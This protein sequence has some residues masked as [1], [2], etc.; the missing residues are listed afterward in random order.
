MEIQFLAFIPHDQ[1]NLFKDKIV[2]R[3]ISPRNN[4]LKTNEST[5]TLDTNKSPSKDSIKESNIDERAIMADANICK[6]MYSMISNIESF[7][8]DQE[9]KQFFWMTLFKFMVRYVRETEKKLE[10]IS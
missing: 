1:K 9:V 3:P 5:K 4:I 10:S 2:F 8:L 7:L 6:H